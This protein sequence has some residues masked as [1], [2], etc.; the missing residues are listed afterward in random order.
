MCHA[1]EN[2]NLVFQETGYSQSLNSRLAECGCRRA[3]QV[4]PDYPDKVVSPSRGIP[5]VNCQLAVDMQQV[6][7][8]SD[9]IQQTGSVCVTSTR[10][11]GLGSQCTQPVLGGTRLIC[12]P[13]SSYLGQSCVEVAGLPC[14]RIILIAP[15]WPNMSCFW[16][17]VAMSSQI[18]MC[19]HKLPN[20]LTQPS[21][22]TPHRNLLNL[23]L[24][25]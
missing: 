14:R 13:T 1:V 8:T 23:N 4:R 2:P 5:V 25:A 6:A 22:Q 16:D 20:L 19:L 18:P 3:S 17:L 9:E 10:S 15:G 7:L 12:P 11:P 21:I 24:H